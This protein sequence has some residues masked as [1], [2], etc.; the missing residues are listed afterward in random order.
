[1]LSQNSLV[2]RRVPEAG[3]QRK[4]KQNTHAHAVFELVSL[5]YQQKL[6]FFHARPLYFTSTS[7]TSTARLRRSSST[8][9]TTCPT[10]SELS[11]SPARRSPEGLEAEPQRKNGTKSHA[12]AISE[13]V[14]LKYLQKLRVCSHPSS[15]ACLTDCLLRYSA[16]SKLASKR[17]SLLAKWFANQLAHHDRASK[18]VDLLARPNICYPN[19]IEASKLEMGRIKPEISEQTI[20]FTSTR[21]Y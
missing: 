13:L 18:M 8:R 4:T 15:G 7:G 20:L 3:T 16:R 2:P 17:A 11:R 6:R 12:H 19:A 9:L 10:F 21:C 5:K 14:S 1:M